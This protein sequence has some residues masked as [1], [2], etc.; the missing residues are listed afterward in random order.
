MYMYIYIYIYCATYYGY[1]WMCQKHPKT[2]IPQLAIPSGKT[3]DEPLDF[4]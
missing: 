4:A 3:D 2:G 1:I